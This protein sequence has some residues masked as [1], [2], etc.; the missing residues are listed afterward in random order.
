MKANTS[1]FQVICVGKKAYESIKPFIIDNVNIKCED[2]VTLLAVNIDIL[3][4]FNSHV[5][6][7]CK[8]ASTQ[9]AVLKRLGRCFNQEMQTDHLQFFY[10]YKF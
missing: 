1:K 4:T 5:S 2:S 9:L 7:I 6:E 10:C 8:K 3:L